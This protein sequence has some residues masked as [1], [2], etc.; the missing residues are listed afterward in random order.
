MYRLK[1]VAESNDKGDWFRWDIAHERQLAAGSGQAD[2]ALFLQCVDFKKACAA[3]DVQAKE[4]VAPT[5]DEEAP[6]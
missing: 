6:F 5:G 2:E 1:T 3:G 4:T